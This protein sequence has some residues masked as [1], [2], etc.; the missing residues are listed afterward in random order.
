MADPRSAR[1]GD[2]DVLFP[3]AAP[4]MRVAVLTISDSAAR[5]ERDDGSGDAAA[6]WVAS[7]GGVVAARALVPD[8]VVP[9]VRQLVEW[10]DADAADLVLTTGGTGLAPRDVTP[11]ATRAAIE[12]EAPGIA[13]RL[14]AVTGATF[15]RAALS[16]GRAG[17]RNRTLI[18]NLPGSTRGVR[19]ML[20]ALEPIVRHAVDIVRGEA[21]GHPPAESGR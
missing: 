11:E 1:S 20:A 7:V 21:T 2:A 8:D 15:P 4:A 6:E 13:E 19:D 9:V 12:R 10:C 14:R 18:V 16:R 3:G 5:G 17:V